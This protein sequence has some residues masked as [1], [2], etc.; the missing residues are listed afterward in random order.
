[1][2]TGSEHGSDSGQKRSAMHCDMRF[3]ARQ[4]LERQSL[5]VRK[6][7]LFG[8]FYFRDPGREP[9][10]SLLT[11]RDATLPRV[12]VSCKIIGTAMAR[13]LSS[14]TGEWKHATFDIAP[15]CG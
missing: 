7:P 11:L 1:M 14:A 6:R 5:T 15:V 10:T 4:H 9:Q 8:H 3:G 13:T 2:T 12:V